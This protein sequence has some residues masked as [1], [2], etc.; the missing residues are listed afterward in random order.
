MLPATMARMPYLAVSSNPTTQ[1]CGAQ[2]AFDYISKDKIQRKISVLVNPK[3]FCL[4][5]TSDSN[6]LDLFEP[7]DSIDMPSYCFRG[8]RVFYA[9]Q[10]RI[11]PVR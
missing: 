8:R 6:V 9:I 7:S 4:C 11:P 2:Y 1:K 3:N 5:C 10:Q